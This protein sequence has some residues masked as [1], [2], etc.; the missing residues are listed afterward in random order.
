M[1]GAVMI[2]GF[3]PVF[4]ELTKPYLTVD[5]ALPFFD[6]YHIW[7]GVAFDMNVTLRQ[8]DAGWNLFNIT[9]YLTYNTTLLSVENVVFDNLWNTTS[10]SMPS[11]G[12]LRLDASSPSATLSGDVLLATVTFRVCYQGGVPP[13]PPGHHDDSPLILHS[14]ELSDSAGVS[15]PTDPAVNGL[16]Q[17]SSVLGG[18]PDI[19]VT[20]FTFP[21][22]AVGQNYLLSF[23]VTVTNYERVSLT[24]NVTVYANTTAIGLFQ[25]VTASADSSAVINVNW[26]TVGFSRGNYTMTAFASP[27]QYEQNTANNNLTDGPIQVTIP[28]DITGPNGKP[29]G[30]V[31]MRDVGNIARRFM[32]ESPSPDYNPNFDIN[33]D[34]IINMVDIGIA[35]SHFGETDL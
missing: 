23:N 22:T 28:G 26:N 8:L 30:K 31:D 18:W 3:T 25:N 5:P 2:V 4:A 17:I 32:T 12:D 13:D 24:F 35:A 20:S 1:M 9:T 16:V 10:W 29:D 6:Q 34:G 27:V 19:A 11:A 15:I 33:D 21:K 7:I 14:Y